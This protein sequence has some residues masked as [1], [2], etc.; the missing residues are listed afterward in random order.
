MAAFPFPLVAAAVAVAVAASATSP[1]LPDVGR[2]D[3]SS[4]CYHRGRVNLTRCTTSQPWWTLYTHDGPG[5]S[6]IEHKGV[7][8]VDGPGPASTNAS[9]AACEASCAADPR[10]HAVVVPTPGVPNPRPP[11]AC[12]ARPP[13]PPTPP[14]PPAPPVPP[15]PPVPGRSDVCAAMDPSETC[16]PEICG[17]GPNATVLLE[18]RTYYQNRS[19]QLP[20]GAR[21]VGAGVNKTFVVACGA[22]SSGRRGFILGNHSYL[23]HFTW[24]GLQARRGNFDAAVGTPGCLSTKDCSAS[25]ECIPPGGDCAG[26][27]NATAEH[28]H[29]RPHADGQAW[30]PL[31]SSA[32]WFPRTRPWGRQRYTGSLNITLRGII[33]WGTWADGINF[34][35]GHHNVLI[36]RCEMSFTGD[37]AYGLWP[38]SE[39]AKADPVSCQTNIVLRNNTGRWPR[40]H[41]GMNTVHSGT[42]AR[43]FPQCDC[44]DVPLPSRNTHNNG[45]CFIHACYATYAGGRGVQW[46]NNR[47]EGAGLFLQ[48]NGGFPAAEQPNATAGTE[49]CGALAVAGNTVAAMP[50]QGSGCMPDNHTS[51]SHGGAAEPCANW[52]NKQPPAWAG[53]FP[54]PATIG[55]QCGAHETLLPPPCDGRPRFAAC[56]AAPGV[57]GA[58]Y[59]EAATQCISAADLASGGGCVGARCTFFD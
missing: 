4:C 37:D 35:G 8:C 51:C 19:I 26:V 18:A 5:G 21:L 30:W 59:T 58:C 2:S 11:S 24:Q 27:M 54:P 49:W 23:G 12:K 14:S 41:A 38:V 57:A 31:S 7:N 22:P 44:G 34:H 48:F 55:G 16:S 53:V 42:S 50:G 20:A 1:Q 32:G 15:R 52:C 56:R 45:K 25:A 47:C 36:E 28:I 29:V 10:C 6:W 46:L 9:V 3:L 33:N 17:L 39:D 43:N 13:A 40:Q